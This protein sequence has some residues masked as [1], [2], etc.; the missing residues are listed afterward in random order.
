MNLCGIKDAK[1]ALDNAWGRGHERLLKMAEDG[2]R[3]ADD[4]G[5]GIPKIFASFGFDEDRVASFVPRIFTATKEAS[6]ISK[7]ED[8]FYRS[9]E[10]S[11]MIA[12]R[13]HDAL[14]I[15]TKEENI[16]LLR[17]LDGDI[18]WDKLDPRLIEDY[19]VMRKAIDDNADLLVKAGLLEES[20]RK[21]HYV[22]RMYSQYIGQ[23]G[24]AQ[25]FFSKKFK[26]KD[27]SEEDRIALNQIK[28]A[29]IVVPATLHKQKQQLA[30]G[31][32]LKSLAESFGQDE[33]RDGFVQI[34]DIQVGGGLK[35]YGALSGKYVPVEVAKSLN[36]LN[37]LKDV[38]DTGMIALEKALTDSAL[39][40]VVDH[41]KVNLTVKNPIT[42][43]ANILSNM[44]LAF[45]NGDFSNLAKVLKLALTDKKEFQNLVD[46]ARRLG[47]KTELED[48]D[49][50]H[51]VIRGL[52][53]ED[54]DTTLRNFIPRLFGNLYMTA[55]ST[56]G[57]FLR[58]AYSW[59]DAIFK[60]ASFYGNKQKGLSPEEAFEIG[61][62]VYV[63]YSTPMPTTY[64]VLDKVGLTPFFHYLYKS[65]PST[66]YAATRTP[67]SLLR[68]IALA[69][70]LKLMGWSTFGNLGVLFGGDAD[71]DHLKPSWAASSLN[72]FLAKSWGRVGDTDY[73]VNVDRFMPAG[74]F[75]LGALMDGNQTFAFG[76]WGALY[77]IA[78]GKTPLGYD[79][80]YKSDEPVDIYRKMI[81]QLAETYMP[82]FSPFGRFG[83]RTVEVL[84][85]TKKNYYDE[86]LELPE[87]F[88]RMMGIR[89]FNTL[90]ETQ[91][92]IGAI[93]KKKK[94]A[95]KR[96]KQDNDYEKY[97][98][99]IDRL[100]KERSQLMYNIYN[101]T[102]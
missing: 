53:I 35:R 7:I 40:K 58:R 60:L 93:D 3:F 24:Q 88:L 46:E 45:I 74:K 32:F 8:T 48:I 75:N 91:R 96:Y 81:Q 19:K 42:H 50:F 47:L 18:P 68:Y 39:T 29:S 87:H 64:R 20:A 61:N 95:M 51:N 17:A 23:Q 84:N 83:I 90:K 11:I 27:L 86:T 59:E 69:S 16:D 78:N 2:L 79:Y 102:P 98:K 85:G 56:T 28:D 70:T 21:E 34:P 15:Y 94:E 65:T 25:K 54:D 44:N 73:F 9:M 6:K 22:L 63:D 62:K 80:S 49:D 12:R 10:D 30:I 82:S 43:L 4:K 72:L 1:R 71:D 41:I 14:R 13:L 66:I 67:S 26:R 37:L 76:F 100:D 92:K 55:N 38:V 97:S 31:V 5:L 89:K 57:K 101:T 52:K 99:A 77:N 33:P 36:H